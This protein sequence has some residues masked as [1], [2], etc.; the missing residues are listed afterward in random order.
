ML[1]VA[2]VTDAKIVYLLA[3]VH[4][5]QNHNILYSLVLLDLSAYGFGGTSSL[6]IELILGG[7]ISKQKQVWAYNMMFQGFQ[8]VGPVAGS[9]IASRVGIRY[10]CASAS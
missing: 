8:V 4:G 2:P 5:V 1:T 7:S 10:T 6:I 3:C 9:D